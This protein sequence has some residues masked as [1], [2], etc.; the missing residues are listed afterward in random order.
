DVYDALRSKRPYKPPFDHETATAIIVNGDDRT[1]PG[2]FDPQLLGIF[3]KKHEL[4]GA[5]FD[6]FEDKGP[7]LLVERDAAAQEAV[8]KANEPDAA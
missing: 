6:L 3:E 7:A 5:L 2:Q 8:S 4:F 1:N